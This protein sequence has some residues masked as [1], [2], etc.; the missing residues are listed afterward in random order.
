MNDPNIVIH[1]I[2]QQTAENSSDG[3][4]TPTNGRDDERQV[5]IDEKHA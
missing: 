3:A 2:L 1:C 5:L 4:L